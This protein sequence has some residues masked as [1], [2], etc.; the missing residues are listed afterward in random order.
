M[1]GVWSGL[2][3]VK[4][5]LGLSALAVV[6]LQRLGEPTMPT[7]RRRCTRSDCKHHETDPAAV[8]CRACGRKLS[9]VEAHPPFPPKTRFDSIWAVIAG[10][11]LI[12]LIGMLFLGFLSVCCF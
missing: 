10:V 3:G 2:L 9:P 5:R 1:F 7:I 6:N 12:F 8:F 4:S 11:I